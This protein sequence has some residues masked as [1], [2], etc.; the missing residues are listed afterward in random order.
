M[1]FHYEQPEFG[2][3]TR[4]FNIFC[5]SSS[6]EDKFQYGIKASEVQNEIKMIYTELW[7]WGPDPV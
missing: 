1:P 3:V 6:I 5:S 7:I 2:W 4:D